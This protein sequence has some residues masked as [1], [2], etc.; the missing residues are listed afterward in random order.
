[1]ASSSGTRSLSV[2][3]EFVFHGDW[4]VPV[5]QLLHLLHLGGHQ[6]ALELNQQNLPVI[7]KVIL[8]TAISVYL[9]LINVPTPTEILHVLVDIVHFKHLLLTR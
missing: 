9:I 1:M 2:S 4:I 5:D 6:P 7:N 8:Y 3:L